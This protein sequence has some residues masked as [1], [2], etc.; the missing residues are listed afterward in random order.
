MV[1]ILELENGDSVLAPLMVYNASFATT[2]TNKRY[3][4][5]MVGNKTGKIEARLWTVNSTMTLPKPGEV[6]TISAT[7]NEFASI[8]QLNIN[9]MSKVPDAD[10]D[11]SDFTIA[12]PN[13]LSTDVIHHL[14]QCVSNA[15]EGNEFLRRLWD[16]FIGCGMLD[17]CSTHTAACGVHHAGLGGWIKHTSEVVNYAYA[18]YCSL[19]VAT[20]ALIR[21]DILMMGAFFHDIGKL[22]AYAFEN[23]VPVMTERGMLIDH[24]VDG[25]LMIQELVPEYANDEDILAIQHII[26]SH[27]MELEW[28]SPVNPQSLEST[29]VAYADNLS[30]SLDTITQAITERPEGEVRTSKVFTQHNKQFRTF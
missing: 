28:G 2:K 23:G 11:I 20:K 14:T 17:E 13:R 30:A 1:N 18:I 4:K 3:L 5:C 26:A 9:L 27:H 7:V 25:C 10:V 19:P 24:I 21:Y 22:R 8:L 12:V 16:K 6:Y 29:I 15:I